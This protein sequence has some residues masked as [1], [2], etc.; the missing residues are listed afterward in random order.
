MTDNPSVNSPGFDYINPCFQ[1]LSERR[2]GEAVRLLQQGLSQHLAAPE[3]IDSTALVKHLHAL[4]SYLEFRL[5]EDFT[6]EG[7][8]SDQ[9][10]SA[11]RRCSFCGKRQSE[12]TRL[13]AGPGVFICDECVNVCSEVLAKT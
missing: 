8:K 3:Q 4:V 6:G 11:E 10:K 13:I 7:S 2:Y 1:A 9:P 12:V 5:E